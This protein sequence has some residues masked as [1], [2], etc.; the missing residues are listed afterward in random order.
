M[1]D[2][3]ALLLHYMPIIVR[4]GT[5]TEWERQFAASIIARS[6]KGAFRPSEKQTAIMRRIVDEFR[7]EMLVAEDKD[8]GHGIG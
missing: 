1:A 6:R 8:E 5:V 3:T 4:S 2:D 7:A